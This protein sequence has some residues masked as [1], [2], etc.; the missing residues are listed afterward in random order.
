MLLVNILGFEIL[1]KWQPQQG[2]TALLKRSIP[3]WLA[4][5]VPITLS[6]VVFVRVPKATKSTN[7]AVIQP[8]IDPYTEKYKYSNTAFLE[9][10]SDLV[11][12][13]KGKSWLHPYPRYFAA[14]AGKNS[15]PFLKVHLQKFQ[16]LATQYPSTHWVMGIQFYQLYFLKPLPIILPIKLRKG[17]GGLLQFGF[18][19]T[20][21]TSH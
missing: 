17:L 6:L 19:G 21:S 16:Q 2:A 20:G 4:I 8:N 1:K 3:W 11:Q 12:P 15:M 18:W 13:L 14:G 5:A 7:V 10:L 9:Q